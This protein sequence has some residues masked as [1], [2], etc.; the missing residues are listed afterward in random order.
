M[1]NDYVEATGKSFS[2][3]YYISE[4]SVSH[5]NCVWPVPPLKQLIWINSLKRSMA[6]QK[7]QPKTHHQVRSRSGSSSSSPSCSWS[8][9]RALSTGGPVTI[10]GIDPT[11]PHREDT[12]EPQPAQE[13]THLFQ[14]L[15]K[16]SVGENRWSWVKGMPQLQWEDSLLRLGIQ[17]NVW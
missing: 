4:G 14:D 10:K 15:S 17:W 9:A 2:L 5:I 1:V 8:R 6:E 12:G 3:S 13:T 11:V 16:P 7:G